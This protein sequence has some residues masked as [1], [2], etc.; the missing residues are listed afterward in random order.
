MGIR[1]DW[2]FETLG[3]VQQVG[4]DPDALAVRA[5]RRRRTRNAVLALLIGIGLAAGIVAYRLHI[6]AKQRRFA[7]ETTV[8]AETLALRMGDRRAFLAIQADVGEWVHI[9]NEAFNRYQALSPH[10]EPSG[11]IVEL[12]ID[13]DQAR[14]ALREM[15]DDQP[16][17]VVWF[18]RYSE[19]GWAH[20]PP[21]IDFWGGAVE[22]KADYF[23]LRYY[24]PDQAFAEQ[25][26]AQ[27]DDW[28]ATACRLAPCGGALQPMRVQIENDPLARI[29]WADYD[30]WTLVIPSPVLGRTPE[31]GYLDPALVATLADLLAAR[32]AAQSF[33]HEP[34]HEDQIVLAGENWRFY[35]AGAG[36]SAGRGCRPGPPGGYP[37][38]RRRNSGFLAQ[39][40]DLSLA[41]RGDAYHRGPLAGGCAIVSPAG[42]RGA[43][44]GGGCSHRITGRHQFH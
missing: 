38:V 41:S 2:E 29:G 15:L 19:A 36:G 16:Y 3:G 10:L 28:M 32:W 27:I 25:L 6:A 21:P 33:G 23:K 14:V 17:R 20:V 7:L 1:L 30:P 39:L 5:R 12:D 31:N 37:H 24:E 26:A 44:C 35:G 42:A 40:P 18:Y 13:A 8:A 11:E 4:E 22:V 34:G 43:G 9:R